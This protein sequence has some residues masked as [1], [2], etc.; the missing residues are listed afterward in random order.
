MIAIRKHN[1]ALSDVMGSSNQVSNAVK[2]L[3]NE[4]IRLRSTNSDKEIQITM[5]EEAF[6]SQKQFLEQRISE[7]EMLNTRVEEMTTNLNQVT[8]LCESERKLRM[9]LQEKLKA[10]EAERNETNAKSK[11]ERTQYKSQVQSEIE[12]HVE[13]NYQLRQQLLEKSST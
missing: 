5:I 2:A 11:L 1:K 4:I 12:E 7:N 13:G 9:E 6:G 10:F 8:N 3:E